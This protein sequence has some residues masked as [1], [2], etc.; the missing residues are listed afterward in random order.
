M[1]SELQEGSVVADAT[2]GKGNDTLFLAN[3]VGPAGRVYAFDIQTEAINFTTQKLSH[4]NLLDRVQLI[5]DSHEKMDYYI[6]EALDAVMFNLGYLPGVQPRLITLPNTTLI[7]VQ[8]A[9]NLLKLGGLMTIVFY[10]GHAGGQEELDLVKNYLTGLPQK[11]FEIC[12]LNFI[13][14]INNPPQLIA[15]KKLGRGLV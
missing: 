11:E 10:L 1:Q 9:L 2:C 7:A 3:L 15:V 12:H 8:K 14:Q 6:N 5:K 4:H 13:N